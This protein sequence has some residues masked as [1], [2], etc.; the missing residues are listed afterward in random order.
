MIRPRGILL[1]FYGTVVEEDDAAITAICEEI[2]AAASA[3]VA[4]Q[5]VALLWSRRFARLC[6]NAHDREFRL[7]RELELRSLRGI[8][9]HFGASLDARVLSQRLYNYW[10]QPRVLPEARSVLRRCRAPVCLVSNIDN[11]DLR[12]ALD[13]CRLSFA[14]VVTSE[15]CAAYK[16]RPAP[17]RRALELL[18]LGPRDVLSVG[19][20][21]RSDVGGAKALGIPTLWLNRQSRILLPEEE[22]PDF[23]AADLSGMLVVGRSRVG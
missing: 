19:D 22:Q 5:Q 23:V 3:R 2:A 4:V 13:H 18:N 16:P 1:D 11:A 14:H 20:S 7:Q 10:R 17:F 6:H 9:R 15:D 12:A 21:L 8:L